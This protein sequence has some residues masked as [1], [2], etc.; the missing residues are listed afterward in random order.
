MV[1]KT[2]ISCFT[3]DQLLANDLD[4]EGDNLTI[5]GFGDPEHGSLVII[6]DPSNLDPSV[7]AIEVAGIGVVYYDPPADFNGVDSF[8]YTVSDG[9]GGTATGTVNN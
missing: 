2:R 4:I 6:Q 5:T 7:M 9:N 8:T 1:S 3:V